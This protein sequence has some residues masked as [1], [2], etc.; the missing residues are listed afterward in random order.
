[1]GRPREQDTATALHTLNAGHTNDRQTSLNA[2]SNARLS[3]G[4]VSALF[5]AVLIPSA[6]SRREELLANFANNVRSHASHDRL[7]L[8]ICQDNS[9]NATML[10][11]ARLVVPS[12]S[13]W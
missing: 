4:F 9:M 2:L 3:L 5:A 12:L 8:Q 7:V 6:L 11:I 13:R 10:T 1:M